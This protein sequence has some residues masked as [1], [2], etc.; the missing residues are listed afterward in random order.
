M[1]KYG[2]TDVK[3][4]KSGT[5]PYCGSTDVFINDSIG[6]VDETIHTPMHCDGCG[7]YYQ[8]VYTFSYA[9]AYDDDEDDA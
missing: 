9:I 8:A 7:R 1:S 6:D 5:C 2:Y 4:I 3:D